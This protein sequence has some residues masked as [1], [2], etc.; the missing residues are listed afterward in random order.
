MNTNNS[1]SIANLSKEKKKVFRNIEKIQKKQ[2]NI[3]SSIAFN[4][5]LLIN[6]IY[7]K[8]LNFKVINVNICFLQT[9]AFIK[10]IYFK[11][12]ISLL[13]LKRLQYIKNYF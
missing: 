8:Y 12:C 6:K 1:F 5:A 3:L 9:Y 7:P 4:K 11:N 13:F 10:L 2:V